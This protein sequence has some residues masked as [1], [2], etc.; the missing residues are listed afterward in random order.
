MS[1]GIRLHR[2]A[3]LALLAA[4]GSGDAPATDTVAVASSPPA[5]DVVASAIDSTGKRTASDC[6]ATGR[7]ALCSFEKRLRRSGFVATKI[8]SAPP[9]RPGFSVQ[10]AVYKLGGG[11]LEVFLYE[12]VAALEKDIAGIDTLTVTPPGTP[13]S[14]PSPAVLVRNGNVAAVYMGQNAREAERLTLAITA[15]A[16]SGG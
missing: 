13:S 4:C 6:P 1:N 3:I 8:D 12:D 7:W 11:R 2:V 14:W 16:P 10:P 5:S 9:S 15:G